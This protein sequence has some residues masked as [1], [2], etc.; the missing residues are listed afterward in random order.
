ME[1]LKRYIHSKIEIQ[2]ERLKDILDSFEPKQ[3]A[4][5]Q[6]IIRAGQYVTKYYFI[7]QG[8]IRIVIATPEKEVTAWLIFENNFFSD[9]EALRNGQVSK[10]KILALENTE[11]YS[12]EASKM[13]RFYKDFPE[14]QEFGRLIM[15]DAFLNVVDSLISFQV[16]DAEA[17]YLKLLQKSDAINRVPLKQL[18][19]YLG[20]TPNS[21]SRIRKNIR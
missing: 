7:A 4:K 9:L 5:D 1:V 15:E 17:R 2:P 21:L 11:I 12:I 16:M 3:Y 13:H 10:A 20:I 6:A 14:W 19:S 18:A 8:G